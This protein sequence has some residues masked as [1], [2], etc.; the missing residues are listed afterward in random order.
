MAAQHHQVGVQALAPPAILASLLP[1]LQSVRPNGRHS[2]GVDAI[3]A[4]VAGM[5]QTVAP[6]HYSASTNKPTVSHYLPTLIKEAWRSEDSDQKYHT[7]DISSR[8]AKLRE[9]RA[10]VV[11]QRFPQAAATGA[12]SD[13]AA[14]SYLVGAS[15]RENVAILL[16]N[17]RAPNTG[18]GGTWREGLA[19]SAPDAMVRPMLINVGSTGSTYWGG[20]IDLLYDNT[21]ATQNLNGHAIRVVRAQ[22]DLEAVGQYIELVSMLCRKVMP[23]FRCQW[24]VDLAVRRVKNDTGL[25]FVAFLSLPTG[26]GYEFGSSGA[27]EIA[28]R[29]FNDILGMLR[30]SM[31][32]YDDDTTEDAVVIRCVRVHFFP[33]LSYTGS[34][35]ALPPSA[36]S[37]SGSQ[38]NRGRQAVFNEIRTMMQLS[39]AHKL[40]TK[41]SFIQA[42]TAIHLPESSDRFCILRALLCCSIISSGL[43]NCAPDTRDKPL[44]AAKKKMLLKET[45]ESFWDDFMDDEPL[46]RQ[47]YGEGCVW[48]CLTM[49][50]R[51]ARSIPEFPT[52]F[53]IAMFN[54]YASSVPVTY[55][56][57]TAT[58]ADDAADESEQFQLQIL[59][60]ESVNNRTVLVAIY[61]QHA[62]LTCRNSI[63]VCN[64]G[65]EAR[66]AS[67]SK[68]IAYDPYELQEKDTKPPNPDPTRNVSTQYGFR[69][70]AGD[71]CVTIDFE[72]AQCSTC[73]DPSTPLLHTHHP[74]CAAIATSTT[75]SH[76]FV[77][78]ECL[79]EVVVTGIKNGCVTQMLDHFERVYLDS[80]LLGEDQVL[81][82]YS[83]NGANFDHFP[84]LQALLSRG[85][86]DIDVVKG[87][88]S[89]LMQIKWR[90]K[91]VFM[92]I[93]K[94]YPGGSLDKVYESFRSSAA[95]RQR[96]PD[97]T[98][99]KVKY[100][101]WPYGILKRE[102]W[103]KVFDWDFLAQHDHLWGGKKADVADQRPLAVVNVDWFRKTFPALQRFDVIDEVKKYCVDDTLITQ[104][105]VEIHHQDQAFGMFQGKF[106][107]APDAMTVGSLVLKMLQQCYVRGKEH[108]LP[109]GP[110]RLM[111]T[112]I[113]ISTPTTTWKPML[114]DMITEATKGGLV[115]NN[116][117]F[118]G[119]RLDN[120][121]KRRVFGADINSSYPNIMQGPLPVEFTNIETF[122]TPRPFESVTFS[123]T[124][125][126]HCSIYMPVSTGLTVTCC[127]SAVSPRRIPANWF[128]T[129]TKSM[130]MTCF[131][132][133]ELKT[134]AEWGAVIHVLE[135]AYFT[136]SNFLQQFVETVYGERL[137]LGQGVDPNTYEAI[138]GAVRDSVVVML[139]KLRLNN[140]FG[141]L[142]QG[143]MPTTVIVRSYE[144]VIDFVYEGKTIVDINPISI[145]AGAHVALEVS[146]FEPRA[147]IGNLRFT[148]SYILAGARVAL[149]VLM[150]E[151]EKLPAV[152]GGM[153][154]VICGDTD[155]LFFTEPEDGVAW[156]HFQDTYF[157]EYRLGACKKEHPPGGYEECISAGKKMY[158]CK[159][160]T[161]S[162]NKCATKGIPTRLLKERYDLFETLL[163]GE[164]ITMDM[165]MSFQGSLSAL[166]EVAGCV[167][168]VR[169]RNITRRWLPNDPEHRSE[170][171]ESLD[172]FMTNN[173][174]SPLYVSSDN[175]SYSVTPC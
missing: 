63:R 70:L 158:C 4:A 59:D 143:E 136:P 12:F 123:N 41:D 89:S 174:P 9:T 144:E 172:D 162:K 13:T 107:S 122:T 119:F 69:N 103:G 10:N 54:G 68:T 141:K 49:F 52:T 37:S 137:S 50:M 84:V 66:V 91:V 88:G 67:F 132:G 106:L 127:N 32:N 134:F 53:T 155:S 130:R 23:G 126:Y 142:A 72:T 1:L 131:W 7:I 17:T 148:A 87:N 46:S 117:R 159:G 48:K 43:V 81:Y 51:K 77:G 157:H 19:T 3:H 16:V 45:V 128:D 129:S 26:Q 110:P 27:P 34:P 94:L 161:P 175:I 58:G 114:S 150:H 140:A 86:S 166:S 18:D 6:I 169:M 74:C 111:L 135:V 102:Y 121:A 11:A 8:I 20:V 167:R 146:W 30:E 125:I 96:F 61:R 171:W 15:E 29:I 33:D 112:G 170:P 22:Q 80:D 85:E 149:Q 38:E 168:S 56:G 92:D 124:A 14:L 40:P 163:R 31:E 79:Q 83:F 100:K 76:V 104:M 147:H 21:V 75:A 60:P 78:H 5:G 28:N 118:S 93:A 109:K 71:Y 82:V 62:F 154:E 116:K 44:Q 55:I 108:K 97:V 165:P 73:S 25:P 35:L 173:F 47:T 138:P 151:V 105:I 64:G 101:C 139:R 145:D 156:Q 24:K 152:G 65:V 2:A 95:I 99:E 113:T 90:Q 160:V 57:I 120:G 133:L 36:P 39:F 164:S 153:C 115:T 42:L 98:A